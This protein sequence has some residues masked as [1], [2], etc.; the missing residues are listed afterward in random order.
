MLEH[1]GQKD[2]RQMWG[3]A[4]AS[5]QGLTT[6]APS[7]PALLPGVWATVLLM[8]LRLSQGFGEL[9]FPGVCQPSLPAA[10]SSYPRF[11]WAPTGLVFSQGMSQ[12]YVN[13]YDT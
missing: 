11:V 4:T 9:L 5:P 3:S 1:L 13:A 6:A 7:C 10:H 12:N 2:G 8:P